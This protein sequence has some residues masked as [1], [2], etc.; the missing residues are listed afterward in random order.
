M[1]C[2]PMQIEAAL[3]RNNTPQKLSVENIY[4][5]QQSLMLSSSQQVHLHV[6]TR[7]VTLLSYNFLTVNY[8]LCIVSA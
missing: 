4:R 2:L 7:H 8:N 5:M 6:T 3:Q 1:I